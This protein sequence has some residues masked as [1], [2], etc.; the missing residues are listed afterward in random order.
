MM[1]IS[2]RSLF[3]LSMT[4]ISLLALGCQTPRF[5]EFEQVKV[6]MSK[7]QVLSTA[8]N[9]SSR[10]RKDSVDR[11]SYSLHDHPDGK[12][13]RE[14]HFVEGVSTYV[15]PK[16]VPVISAEQQDQ[17]NEIKNREAE[18]RERVDYSSVQKQYEIHRFVPVDGDD[19]GPVLLEQ[20]ASG[21]TAR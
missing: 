2:T 21:G 3:L 7:E 5:R 1:G 17:L 11:W 6:G 20:K 8:G 10:D 9:P 14:V 18:E 15:G 12:T 4:A 19:E 16:L 13:V